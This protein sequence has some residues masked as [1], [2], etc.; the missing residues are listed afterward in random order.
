MLP[1]LDCRW[2]KRLIEDSEDP[3]KTLLEYLPE[4]KY[5]LIFRLDF[6]K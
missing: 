4:G 5:W 3:K 1:M 6:Y 2:S